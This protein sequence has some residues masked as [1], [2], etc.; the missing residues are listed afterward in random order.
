M[1]KA[2][3]IF[4]VLLL[5]IACG[6]QVVEKPENLI[7][8]DKMADIIY[9]L[10]ILE[11]MRSQKPVI[12]E[13]NGINQNTYIYKKYGIDSLQFAKS[14]QYY[15]SDIDAYKKIYEEVAKRLEAQKTGGQPDSNA[16]A[17]K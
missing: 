9:D 14:N 15:A 16:G 4:G 13:N 11:A 8:K 6:K 10:A 5:A 17:I 7:G 12:L 2:A 3:V 1:K